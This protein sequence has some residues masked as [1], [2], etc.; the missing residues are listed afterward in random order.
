MKDRRQVDLTRSS[1]INNSVKA[2]FKLTLRTIAATLL[3]LIVAAP[4]EAQQCSQ[5]S[6]NLELV[7]LKKVGDCPIGFYEESQYCVPNEG[8]GQAAIR[9]LNGRCPFQFQPSGAYCLA[10]ATYPNFVIE[11]ISRD[12]PRGWFQ[13]E[14][15]CVKECPP[16]QLELRNV[17]QQRFGP[18]L[19]PR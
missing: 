8:Q 4:A 9:Q 16:L 18:S 5:I 11:Q 3:T 13:Q 7:P 6:L 10:P 14:G 1:C 15:F 12:C 17:I 2:T 19:L